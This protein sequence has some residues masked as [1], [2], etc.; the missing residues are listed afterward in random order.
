[1]VAPP[2]LDGVAQ[3]NLTA[4]LRALAAG[5]RGALGAFTAVTAPG[6]VVGVGLSARV[7]PAKPPTTLAAV[8]TT[9]RPRRSGR[10]MFMGVALSRRS[11]PGRVPVR[12][13]WR[14]P[15]ESG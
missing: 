4:V 10:M 11:G 6:M 13:E 3:V 8:A 1:M 7:V 15:A 12:G 14:S 9:R 5:D 2:L